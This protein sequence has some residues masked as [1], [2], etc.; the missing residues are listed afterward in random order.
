MTVDGRAVAVANRYGGVV[1]I[2]ARA[3]DC[4][5]ASTSS[6]PAD[7][8]PGGTDDCVAW[9]VPFPEA[10]SQRPVAWTSGT[11]NEVTCEW[12]DQKLWTAGRKSRPERARVQREMSGIISGEAMI[13]TY[14]DH[15][16]FT[17][18][19]RWRSGKNSSMC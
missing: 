14:P 2:W 18:C 17:F 9:Y 19:D 6:G 11:L 15:D 4:A 13:L 1:K 7:V 16:S 8:L 3:E 5:G 12:E 10:T